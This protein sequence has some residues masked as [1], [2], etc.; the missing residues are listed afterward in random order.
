VSDTLRRDGFVVV[1]GGDVA[2]MLTPAGT[3]EE[4]HLAAFQASWDDL[5]LDAYMGDGGT[6]RSR[7][8]ATFR[9]TLPSGPFVRQPPAPHYQ[10][11][12]HNTL[13]GGIAREFAEMAPATVENP[14]LQALFRLASRVF[15]EAGAAPDQHVEVHQ[16]RID[17]TTTSGLP[18]PEGPHRDGV[19]FVLM[20]L[21]RRSNVTGAVSTISAASGSASTEF[22]LKRTLDSAM[23]DDSRVTHSVSAMWPDAPDAPAHRDVLIVTFR[24]ITS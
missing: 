18:T 10:A 8:Y 20:T 12:E 9:T 13:N 21:I 19:D 23:V 17:S 11:V 15:A 7:R 4:E 6:Y 16:I 14:A 3:V 1:G 5:P 24:A 22:T 2:A